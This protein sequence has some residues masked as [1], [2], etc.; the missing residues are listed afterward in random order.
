M[1]PLFL[2]KLRMETPGQATTAD[3]RIGEP[4]HPSRFNPQA[5][6]RSR[7]ARIGRAWLQGTLSR[8]TP[9]RCSNGSP[10][11]SPAAVCPPTIANPR[12]IGTGALC[13]EGAGSIVGTVDR[14]TPGPTGAVE[15]SYFHT[16]SRWVKNVDK[17]SG[18]LLRMP[19]GCVSL[20]VRV[21]IMGPFMIGTGRDSPTFL[22]F[23]DPVISTRTRTV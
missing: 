16:G 3:L 5:Y 1:P 11:R 22:H 21:E 23:C 10:V 2:S 9:N 15:V 7:R 18:H 13:D 14:A 19:T 4:C 12:R 8:C 20:R 6:L 17:Q